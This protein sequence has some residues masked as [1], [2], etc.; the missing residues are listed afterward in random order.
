MP[1]ETQSVLSGLRVNIK[2]SANKN[3]LFSEA[4]YAASVVE[5]QEEA[6][7]STGLSRNSIAKFG[8]IQRWAVPC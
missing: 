1:F 2:Y 7:Q 3:S 4:S 5:L 6:L 8:F